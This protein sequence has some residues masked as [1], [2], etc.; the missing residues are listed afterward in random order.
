MYRRLRSVSTLVKPGCFKIFRCARTSTPMRPRSCSDWCYLTTTLSTIGVQGPSW[1]THRKSPKTYGRVSRLNKSSAEILS[2]LFLQST[3]KRVLPRLNYFI[4]NL[5][6]RLFILASPLFKLLEVWCL[7]QSYLRL[8]S[9]G[10]QLHFRKD[11][12]VHISAAFPTAVH[13]TP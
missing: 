6:N 11:G 8:A 2:A 4:I 10:R 3:S 1:T 7:I 12:K 13:L 9:C 5:I